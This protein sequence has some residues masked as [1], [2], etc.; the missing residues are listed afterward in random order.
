MM[1]KKLLAVLL[2]IV[3]CVPSASVAYR[4]FDGDDSTSIGMTDVTDNG[5]EK[6]ITPAVSQPV[7]TQSFGV[8]SDEPQGEF[9][10]GVVLIKDD[11]FDESK[12]NGFQYECCS[13]LFPNSIWY[14]I[15]LSEGVDTNNT[16]KALN[17]S[18]KFQKVDYDYV[19]GADGEI[20]SIDVS[21]NP[22]AS[23]QTY[24]DTMCIRD[25][26]GHLANNS[27]SPGGNPSIVVAVID[28][29][30]DYNHIDLRNNIWVNSAEIPDNGIDDDGNGY[31]DDYRGWNFVANTNDPM[32]D[33]GHGTHV[34]GIVAAEN[35]TI[36][37]V[38]VAW[39]CKVMVLK[40]G[41]S[42][43]YFT[44]SSIAAAVQYAYMNGASVINMSFGGSSISL[45][46]KDALEDAY[47]QCVLVAAAGNEGL[48][49]NLNHYLLHPVGETY[50]AALPFVIG[51]M[52]C[53]HNGSKVSSFSNYDDTPYNSI[54]YEVYSCG[55]SIVSTWPNNKVA[56]LSG[57]SMACPVVAGIAALLRSNFMDREQYSN[58][59]IQSQITNTGIIT[60]YNSILDALDG[61]HTVADMVKA[62]TSIPKPSVYLYDYY[63]FDN[64]E[65]SENNNGDGI[66]DAGETI[67]IAIELYNRGGVASNVVATIDTIRNSDFS[68]IDPYFDLKTSQIAMSDI[69]T[70]S[71]RDCS[72]IYANG[73]VIGTS[74]YFE[75]VVDK[76][77]PH[78]YICDFNLN[79]TYRNGL[80]GTDSTNYTGTGTLQLT[81]SNGV[82]LPSIFTEDTVLTAN[83]RYIVST[84]VMIPAGVTVNV[85]PGV[86][87]IFYE[88]TQAYYDS[89]YNSPTINVHGALNFNGTEDNWIYIHPSELFVDYFCPI[90]TANYTYTRVINL[91]GS[92]GPDN[93][94][95]GG[96]GNSYYS[97]F[98]T[99]TDNERY[100]ILAGQPLGFYN[101][102]LNF[103]EF[104]HSYIRNS[105]CAGSSCPSGI[106]IN[107]ATNSYFDLKYGDGWYVYGIYIS[108]GGNNVFVTER[109]SYSNGSNPLISLGGSTNNL[110][111]TINNSTRAGDCAR[112]ATNSASNTLLDAYDLYHETLIENYYST[113][114]VPLFDYSDH[115]QSD[116]S[117]LWPFVKSITIKD[118]KGTITNVVGTEECSITVEFN[119]EVREDIQVMFGSTYPFSDYRINGSFITSS[120]WEGT[121]S[122]KAMIEN[123]TNY[124]RIYYPADWN[125]SLVSCKGYYSF[126]INTTD[127]LSMNINA[128]PNE[129]GVVLSWNQDDYET[130]M[131]YN[132][133]R[134]DEKD[135]N[136]VKIN[137]TVIPLDE[138]TFID[139]DAEPGETYWYTF[140]VVLSDMTETRPA[141]KVSCTPLD[142]IN[143]TIYHTPINQGYLENNI[144]I[145]C[146]ARDN[147][148]IVSAMLYY[149]TIGD[150]DWKSILMSKQNDR[151]NGTIFGSE[152]SLN[153][154]EYYIEVFDGVNTVSK[155]TNSSPY[156]VII[157]DASAISRIGDVDGDG[158][159]TTRDALM[160]MKAKNDDIILTDDQFI[161]ADLNKDGVL[162]S[163]EALRILQYINGKVT[164]LAM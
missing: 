111:M 119:R 115:S 66:I 23:E 81:V 32:D 85:D 58:K 86:E 101:Q 100:V 53:N 162:S 68:I 137:P 122:I 110:F 17:E 12:L 118:N 147:V 123:G 98:E 64:I 41:N 104:D 109:T 33:N 154:L 146:T 143:P 138:T 112:I 163:S 19:M 140:T 87:I 71:I 152:L 51:V 90:T 40:A 69:G 88:N 24:L 89:V 16:V 38:G 150:N 2:V 164:T 3:M 18:G 133:Y 22:N 77:C 27:V 48:C 30:V 70:Y 21:S 49:N 60:P 95:V 25:G 13:P 136:Y 159:I 127:S 76:D 99:S 8:L 125:H 1:S 80:D 84:D 74:Q 73:I 142:T 67:R 141:G 10:E 134:S 46:V 156:S 61:A 28:T 31:V 93:P 135:G 65:Y 43:G 34:A 42:S 131:G 116:L 126:D 15:E 82:K 83:H 148:G 149:R 75:I 63:T 129:K 54:E 6:V 57:T 35:N 113:E 155:G 153:G 37:T 14:R 47:Y 120:V 4:A 56:M 72:L 78:D 62:L 157:K 5:N 97:S 29:G 103:N 114:G 45:A 11:S 108:S 117:L 145:S 7:S 26:W 144:V 96:G 106:S 59:F 107:S 52:S 55:E 102:S 158:T 39:N 121:F 139:S 50:P 130:L 161:R 132:I 20:E 44:N 79:Y 94:L 91:G 160:I 9:V 124:F 36:G 92:F 105:S 128:N 151:F